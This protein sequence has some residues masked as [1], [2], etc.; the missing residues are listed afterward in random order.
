MKKPVRIVITGGAGQIAYALAFRIAA[1]EM[2]GSEQPIILHLLEVPNALD[3]LK[4]VVMELEDCAYPLL[5]DIVMTED[6]K[7]AFTDVN[8]ALLVGARP[9]GPG[10]ERQDLLRVN[11]DIFTVQGQAL[12]D[13][14]NPQVKVLVVGNPANTNAYIAMR[15][16]PDLA[17]RQFSAMTRLDHHRAVSQL[18][19]KVGVPVTAINQVIIWGNHSATQYPDINHALVYNQSILDL[20]DPDWAKNDFI[21]SVQQRGA[22]IIDIRGKSS[23]ASAAFA[24]IAHMRDWITGTDT[25]VSMAVPSD[26]SYG[27]A[28][29][30]IYSFPVTINN[31]E[32][33]IVSGLEIDEFSRTKMQASQ[34]E[35]EQER[36]AIIDLLC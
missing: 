33:H 17:P 26:G 3:A 7:V 21:T 32:Y 25:W 28:E 13:Y 12:N 8:Y 35:L 14:A 31:G 1:G 23:A 24:A 34:R 36:N 29:E 6:V 20:V 19:M 27:I 22:A 10:M 11:G 2:L 5:Q 30:F 9:R 15:S 16:A 18:A 4:G